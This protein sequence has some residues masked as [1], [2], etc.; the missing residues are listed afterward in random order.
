MWAT[1]SERFTD[2]QLESN[3]F[4][5]STV[6]YPLKLNIF[7]Y[8]TRQKWVYVLMQIFWYY[9]FMLP[10]KKSMQITCILIPT[11]VI[12]PLKALPTLPM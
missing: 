6:P 12:T 4:Y 5:R 10:K 1:S 9:P 3:Y 2:Y 7:S 11:S 8:E